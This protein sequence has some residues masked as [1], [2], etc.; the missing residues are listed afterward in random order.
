MFGF[1]TVIKELYIKDSRSTH[2]LVKEKNTKFEMRKTISY[3]AKFSH[4]EGPNQFCYYLLKWTKLGRT[5]KF[6]KKFVKTIFPKPF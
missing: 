6:S 1:Q 4:P 5:P 3:F 2:S